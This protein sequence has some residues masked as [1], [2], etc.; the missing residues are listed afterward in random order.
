MATNSGAYYEGLQYASQGVE[1][2]KFGELAMGFAKIK[3]DQRL[4]KKR[5]QERR[6][7]TQMEMTKLFGEEIYSPFDGTGLKNTDIFNSKLKDV[8]IGRA[9][10]LNSLYEKG[11]ITGP[12]MMQRMV[13]LT[14]QS[15]KYAE[16]AKSASSKIEQYTQLGGDASEYSNLMI[17]SFDNAMNLAS[18][19]VDPDDNII[20][21][22]KDGD[23]VVGNRLDELDKFVDVRK[24]YDVDSV[25]SSIISSKAKQRVV[26]GGKVI[27]KYADVGDNEK[28]AFSNLVRTLDDGDKFDIAQG[29]GIPVTRDPNS[30]FRITNTEEVDQAIVEKMMQLAQERIDRLTSVDEVAG[31][32]LSVQLNQDYRAAENFKKENQ[33]SVINVVGDKEEDQEI[34]VFPPPG[35]NVIVKSIVARNKTIPVGNIG[36]YIVNNKGEHKVTV[37]YTTMVPA[38]PSVGN[39]PGSMKEVLVTEDLILDD[40]AT[41]NQVRSQF[42]MEPISE[43]AKPTVSKPKPY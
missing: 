31:K 16:A 5:D 38:E 8:I 30:T 19:A 20:V 2:V 10:V 9:N 3:E 12:Q 26:K 36:N 42:G 34:Q 39:K 1:P 11:Q 7:A 14:A 37:S 41:I 18:P 6:E 17:Q 28:S 29:F 13:K 43:R 4:E 24:K 21:L 25:V 33:N 15:K 40:P 32:Q 23:Q 27:E 35:K 22:T